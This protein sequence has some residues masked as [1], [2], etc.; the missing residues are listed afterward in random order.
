MIFFF[1]RQLPIC[2]GAHTVCGIVI[3]AGLEV[4]PVKKPGS[5]FYGSN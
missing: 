4:D 3:K 1:L 2:V 5:G